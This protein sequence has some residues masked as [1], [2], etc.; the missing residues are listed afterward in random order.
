MKE[1]K[2]RRD[3]EG[4]LHLPG[5]RLQRQLALL[6][7]KEL[8]DRAGVARATVSGLERGVRGAQASTIKA[9]AEALEVQPQALIDHP[10]RISKAS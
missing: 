1:T 4:G 7:Q 2:Y 10:P 6:T 8:A 5:L 3:R 9:L